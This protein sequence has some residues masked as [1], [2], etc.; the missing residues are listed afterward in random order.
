MNEPDKWAKDQ[1]LPLGLFDLA[2][3]W[4]D[5]LKVLGAGNGTGLIAAGA[6]LTTLAKD[7]PNTLTYIKIGG[8]C[9]FVGVVTFA[10]GFAFIQLAI[11]A[12]DDM[13]HAL[14]NREREE[15]EQHQNLSS[16]AMTKANYLAIVS[17]LAFFAGLTMGLTAILVTEQL[18]KYKSVI[19]TSPSAKQ[20]R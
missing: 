19:Q 13:L 1:L 8:A 10:L 20:I 2:T 18:P 9:F 11:F 4:A 7:H 6:A 16:A 5:A 3:K 15:A 12:H 17:A 14:R